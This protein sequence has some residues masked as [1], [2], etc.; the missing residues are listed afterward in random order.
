MK[1]QDLAV[2]MLKDADK[3]LA[4]DTSGDGYIRSARQYVDT[5]L[6]LLAIANRR[7]SVENQETNP[8]SEECRYPIYR[9]Y[10]PITRDR[11]EINSAYIDQQIA[12]GEAKGYYTYEEADFV[13]QHLMCTDDCDYGVFVRMENDQGIGQW[14]ECLETAKGLL[15]HSCFMKEAE[16]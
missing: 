10:Y 3:I 16:E 13:L 15:V 4:A 12:L 5:A 7:E 9:Q 2:A 6:L 8:V 11:A 14:V 1:D